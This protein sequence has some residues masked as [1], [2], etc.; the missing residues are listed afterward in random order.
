MTRDTRVQEHV[1]S[2]TNLDRSQVLDGRRVWSKYVEAIR[3][4]ALGMDSLMREMAIEKL[5]EVEFQLRLGGGVVTKI[6]LPAKTP[7]ARLWEVEDE[8]EIKRASRRGCL[9][10]LQLRA[11]ATCQYGEYLD[12]NPRFH[13]LDVH[14]IWPETLGGPTVGWNV[15]P[16]PKSAHLHLLHRILDELV[17]Q[18]DP[19]TRVRLL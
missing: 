19:G 12:T 9:G 11:K 17:R 10:S 16:L 18:T 7:S 1:S 6:R 13:Y 4:C 2:E 5:S 3:R 15:L 14:H 8:Y